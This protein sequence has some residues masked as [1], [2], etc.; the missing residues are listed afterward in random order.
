MQ[1]TPLSRFLE[2]LEIAED[3]A[4]NEPMDYFKAGRGADW[5][6]VISQG[7]QRL[8]QHCLAVDGALLSYH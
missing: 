5:L 4:T 6:L 2:Q 3:L 7:L 8:Q 1:K